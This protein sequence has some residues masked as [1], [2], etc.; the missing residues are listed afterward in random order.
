MHAFTPHSDSYIIL[1]SEWLLARICKRYRARVY[2]HP[3]KWSI[4][5]SDLINNNTRAWVHDLHSAAACLCWW[6]CPYHCS[7]VHMKTQAQCVSSMHE[8][9]FSNVTLNDFIFLVLRLSLKVIYAHPLNTPRH[10]KTKINKA[11]EQKDT[12]SFRKSYSLA[13]WMKWSITVSC[14]LNQA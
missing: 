3:P 11:V 13:S 6:K 12:I 9:C 14:L 1:E 7:T 4:S 8:L 5:S 10:S 2:V